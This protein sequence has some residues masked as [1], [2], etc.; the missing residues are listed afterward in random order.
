MSSPATKR[1]RT[2]EGEV[3]TSRA[4]LSEVEKQELLLRENAGR[5]VLFPL[6]HKAVWDMYKQAEADFWVVEEVDLSADYK[7]WAKMTDDERHFVSHTLAFFAASEG[8][9][10]S[11]AGRFMTDV[12]IPEAR[13][14]YGFQIAVENIHSE[15]YS[16]LLDAFVKGEA[17][18]MELISATANAPC[19][20]KRADWVRRWTGST[21][22]FAERLVA[23]AVAEG[24]FFSGSFCSIFWLKKRWLMPGLIYSNELICRDMERHTDFA[25]LLYSQLAHTRLSHERV[26]E[27]LLEAVAIEKEVVCDTLPVSMIGVS[28][29]Q[30][31]QRIEFCTDYLLAQLGYPKYFNVTNP[32]YFPSMRQ[33]QGKTGFFETKVHF[34][35]KHKGG[36][37]PPLP[38]TGDNHFSLDHDF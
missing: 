25:C 21:N 27:I 2:E 23:F 30:M 36:A 6:K 37:A 16:V 12:Q 31:V 13:C 38:D 3:D 18:K 19:V 14:F 11:L 15:M 22:T 24:M 7:D 4:Q 20:G 35:H 26:L 33:L 9:V 5:H 29:D 34:H 8:I 28:I 1:Q 32:F 10:Q 17:E